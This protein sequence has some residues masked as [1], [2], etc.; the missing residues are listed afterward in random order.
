[1]LLIDCHV[2]LSALI[3]PI[4]VSKALNISLYEAQH[5]MCNDSIGYHEFLDKF[6]I[7]NDIEWD[8]N[9]LLR[10][11]GEC[12]DSLQC[13]GSLLRYSI[14]KYRPYFGMSDKSLNSMIYGEIRRVIPT[15]LPVLSIKYEQEYD[16]TRQMAEDIIFRRTPARNVDFVGNEEKA[17]QFHFEMAKKLI[18]NEIN[19]FMHVGE[20]GNAENVDN[21]IQVGVKEISHGIAIS[22]H[23]S[24][25]QSAID[26][27]VTFHIGM[28][29]NIMTGA[30]DNINDHPIVDMFYSGLNITIGSDDPVQCQTTLKR[31]YNIAHDLF[32]NKTKSPIRTREIMEI[33][34]QN[35]VRA[36]I[37]CGGRI[38]EI[39]KSQESF[40]RSRE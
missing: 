2:H 36:Y 28:T 25:I 6:T 18:D 9:L 39:A 19:V 29:S 8:F 35:G 37:N 15:A 3:S 7:L 14:D 13:D 34:Q 20:G 32:Y 5:K 10:T 38:D 4:F 23:K 30:V 31:E 16:V 27:D 22:G 33:F 24:I 26:N 17:T 40:R 21:A 12:E 11:L 1:M